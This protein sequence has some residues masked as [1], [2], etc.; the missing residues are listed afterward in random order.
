M[1]VSDNIIEKQSIFLRNL[2]TN[3]YNTGLDVWTPEL[4]GYGFYNVPYE[5]Q[6]GRNHLYYLRF[7]YKFTTTN[8]SP[9]WVTFYTQGGSHNFSRNI[10]NPTAGTE[11]TASAVGNPN[12]IYGATLTS[13]TIYNGESNAISGVKSQVKN[14][15]FYD[16]TE[17][18]EV[19]KAAEVATTNEAIKTWCDNNLS[20]VPRYTNYNITN[21]VSGALNKI[22][23]KK[24]NV[25]ADN[26]VEADGLD[27]YATSETIGRYKYFDNGS[28]LAIYNNK[29]NGTVVHT[30]VD[31]QSQNSPFYTE[32]P[33][34]LQ[35]ATNGEATP[36][37]G[38]FVCEHTAAANRIVIERFVAKIPVGY[39]VYAAY[40]H[41]GANPS[42]TFL[43]SREGTGN[44]KE[45]AI[46]Y[47]CDSVTSSGM[48]F[49]TGG[50]VYISGSNN[51]S[52]TWY[53]AYCMSAIITDN[54]DLKNYSILGNIE[55]IKGGYY[56]TRK[57]DTQNLTP[58]GNGLKQVSLPNG[59]NYD[60]TDIAGHAAA[61]IVQ[62]V[63]ANAGY[64][65]IYIPVTSGQRY[66]ISMWIKSKQDMTSFLVAIMTYLSNKSTGLAHTNVVYKNGTKTQLTTAL[67]SGD[68]LVKVKNSANWTSFNYSKLGFRS[69]SNTGYN[70]K[71]TSNGYN[72]STG[73]VKGIIDST[74]I[75]LNTAYTGNTM[76]VNTYIVESYDGSTY[77]YPINKSMLPTDN[78]WKYIEGY[79]GSDALWDG[80]SNSGWAGLTL[81]TAYALLQLNLYSNTGTVP[82]KYADIKIEPITIGNCE[83]QNEKIQIIGGN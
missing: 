43:T 54:E 57:I 18:A 41:Q 32:H 53:L 6:L 66:K 77:P 64:I 58:W 13:G 55:R 39:T 73:I 48:S 38:G 72:G 4:T 40:N 14:V 12:F 15:L 74:T 70:D 69:A 65:P 26:F 56:F 2:N 37:A 17:L 34:V 81:P 21:L 24:G 59:W 49:S 76:P 1:L 78:T 62:P 5:Y 9:T 35:I 47:K 11:Y 19:L 71:G 8:Q 3:S 45:Y 44:W 31:A 22:A 36:G 25:I 68:T 51:T 23:I 60:T 61:S 33:H 83:C 80:A 42:V 63:N 7:T 16:I 10:S 75:E 27:F 30:I 79:F 28:A 20:Y 82:I 50:H 29:Q 46:L 67:N 52:V